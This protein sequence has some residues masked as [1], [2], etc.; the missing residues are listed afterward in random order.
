M[1]IK[2]SKILKTLN[3]EKFTAQFYIILTK[4]QPDSAEQNASRLMNIAVEE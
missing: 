2:S 4:H 3:S 1:P